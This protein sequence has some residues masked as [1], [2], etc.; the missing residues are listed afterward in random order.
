MLECNYNSHKGVNMLVFY[1]ILLFV[2]F[3]AVRIKKDG[4]VDNILDSKSTTCIKG[5]LCFQ[6]MLHNLGLD[7][8]GNSE[9]MELV[10]EH[11]GGIGVGL[12]FFLSAFGII[13]SY[14]KNGNKY[15]LKL[16]FVNVIKLYVIS[17]LINLLIYFMF[18]EGAFT[19][20]DTLLRIFN[21]DVFNDFNRMNRHG[22]YIST[23]IG[24]YIIFAIIFYICSKLK[25][26][27]RFIIAGIVL[28]VIAVGFRLGAQIADNGGM[29]TRE[30]P[31]FALGALYATFYKQINAFLNKYFWYALALSFVGFWIGFFTWEAIGAYSCCVLIVTASQRITYI[32]NISYFFGKICLGVYLFLYPS[33]LIL[34][35]F[36]TNQYLWVLTNAG[37]I[38]EFSVILYAVEYSITYV[39]KKIVSR[40]RERKSIT[41]DNNSALSA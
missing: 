30:I 16:V 17:V 40:I 15:L 37:L 4:N 1:L 22:W 32:N 14:Q 31:C 9:I 33:T 39:I 19:T 29:Y 28:A 8:K 18:F 24:M 10:C 36:V 3:L 2:P 6:V 23:I 38:I 34:Q 11:T 5:I 20:T 27:K 26:E 21:L 25:T 41:P 12:F 13:R 7:Y 35:S